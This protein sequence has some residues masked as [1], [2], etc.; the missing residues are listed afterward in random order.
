MT[1]HK[2]FTATRPFQPAERVRSFGASV[3]A[4]FTALAI[5]HN[6]VNLGQGFPNFPAPDFVKEA[7]RNAIAADIN[8]YARS[9][10][11]ARLVKALAHVYG[12]LYGRELDPLSEMVVT[13]GAT[14]AIFATIQ[15]LINPGDEVILIEP[16][17]D[18]YPAS[19][20]MAGG[21]PVYVPLRFQQGSSSAAEWVLD[22]DELAAAFSPKT[23]LL[24]I[25]TPMNPVGKVFTREELV[26]IANLVQ[27]H[28]VLLLSD[29]V[30]EWMVYPGAHHV[31]VA[32]LPGMWER[33]VTLG[34]AGKTFSVTGW[35]IGWAIAPKPLAHAITMAHQW[36]PFAVATPFQEAV[37]AAFEQ[38]EEQGY[39]EWLSE[40]YCQK[41]NKLLPAL[42]DVG[43][44]PVTPDGS[45]FIIV[46]TTHLDVPVPP[47]ER[48]DFAICRWLTSTVGVAA[49]P[50]SPF[51]SNEHKYLTDNLAR[52]TFCKTDEMLDE[53]VRRLTKNL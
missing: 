15:A 17:Y 11:H 30:Y 31:R 19:V 39:F 33:T 44:T 9:A 26:K 53:A 4:E 23:R 40:M 16:F 47:G 2:D 13:T 7:A 43:L 35:K 28:D 22:Y 38:V 49:I 32:T 46:D 42:R 3:F 34:S 37:G 21:T 50:P 12:P 8:Q 18:S 36:I 5:Q 45:Y 29:E 52:F 27:Q 25:N 51:Y 24:V 10:G 6:A 41:R 20:I 1:Q 48:R 14:E